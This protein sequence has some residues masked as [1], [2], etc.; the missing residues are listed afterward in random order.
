MKLQALIDFMETICPPSL[1]EEWD[2]VGLLLGSR[3]AKIEKEPDIFIKYC[4][5]KESPDQPIRGFFY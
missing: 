4:S 3:S 2:N 5:E 1:A